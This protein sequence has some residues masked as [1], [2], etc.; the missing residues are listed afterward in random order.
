[1]MRNCVSKIIKDEIAEIKENTVMQDA[2]ILFSLVMISKWK[3]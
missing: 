2:R 3:T 1:M